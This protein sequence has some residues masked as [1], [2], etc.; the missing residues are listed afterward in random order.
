MEK[1]ELEKSL[2]FNYSKCSC[3]LTL[4]KKG[5]LTK[6]LRY[7]YLM[8]NKMIICKVVFQLN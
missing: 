3:A 8:E 4:T 6:E 1:L 2:D 5:I 7:V